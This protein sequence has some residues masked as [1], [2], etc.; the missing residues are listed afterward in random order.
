MVEHSR[1]GTMIEFFGGL[2]VIGGSKIMI[3]TPNARVLLDIGLDIPSGTDLFRAPVRPR[4]GRELA[5]YLSTG[6]APAMPGV[7]DPAMLPSRGSRA[8]DL[9]VLG[10]PDPRPSAIFLSHPHIDHD[11]MLGFVRPGLTCYAHPDA[12]GLHRALALSGLG[13]AGH[14]VDLTPAEPGAAIEIG[15]LLIEPIRVDHDVPGACGYLVTAPDGRIAYTGDINTHRDEGIH[16]QDFAD[17]VRGVDVLITETTMLS[18]DPLPDEPKG[19]Q[20]VLQTITEQLGGD[21]LQLISAYERDVE[22]MQS[23]ISAAGSR[24]RTMVWPGQQAAFLALMGVR[25]VVSWDDSR[26]QRK[27]HQIAM[28]NALA[29]GHP[30]PTV[31]LDEVWDHPGDYLVELD[32]DDDPAMLDLP[33]TTETRWIHSQGEP[34]GPYMPQWQP[35]MDWL[36]HLGVQTVRAGSSGHAGP[37]S[38]VDLVTAINPRVVYP[39]HGFRPEA[40]AEALLATGSGPTAV[41]PEAGQR[42]PLPVAVPAAGSRSS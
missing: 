9:A 22:R 12:V 18:F 17:R 3:S 20:H 14:P 42:Y 19:E 16:T 35:F 33:I 39:I 31:S 30:V 6:Q 10:E 11:G 28:A 36:D 15:D 5:D 29:D 34:L 13:P 2:G 23:I 41:V 38:L 8:T 40:L 7:Y 26:P 1:Q 4:P 24:G 37:Q 32:A 25:N 27:P 21:A